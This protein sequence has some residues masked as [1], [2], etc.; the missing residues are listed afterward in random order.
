MS[1]CPVTTYQPRLTTDTI[2]GSLQGMEVSSADPLARFLWQPQPVAQA[3]VAGLTEKFLTLCPAARA[4]AA[5]MR[6]ETAT[7]FID[8]IDHLVVPNGPGLSDQLSAAGFRPVSRHGADGVFANPDGIFPDILVGGE[9][10]RAG[11]AVDSVSDAAAALGIAGEIAGAPASPH[12]RA[13]LI[14]AEHAELWAIERHG[15]DGYRLPAWTAEQS[16]WFLHHLD[17]FRIR[18]RRFSSETEGFAFTNALIDHAIADLG[19]DIACDVFFMAE[20]DYWQRRNRAARVQKGRQDQLGLGWA[21]HDHHTYRS[22]RLWFAPLIATL[23]RLGFMCR[24]R[25]YAGREAGWG[26]QVLEH[27][28][29][30]IVIFADVDMS[31]EEVMGD[32]SHHPMTESDHLG[33][34]GLWCGLHGEAFFQA[35]MHHLE[36]TFDYPRLRDQ[37]AE[38]GI[39]S[40][41]PF[42]DY[43]HLHQA[44]TEGEQW[45][46]DAK[47]VEHLLR[48]GLIDPKQA[49]AF[50]DQGAIGSHLENLERND[51]FKGFNQKGVSEIIAGTD[52]R[53]QLGA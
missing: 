41:K 1:S 7:R 9:T 17:A 31:A 36:C 45:K 28:V 50:K 21:N 10:V 49:T 51:G 33:T 14:A 37:L 23:E 47:R 40:M 42:T 35:G 32:F 5:R 8:W 13:C 15:Y 3:F 29:T 4:L 46:V 6:D 30:G 22:S 2:N 27:P 52:P 34:V 16:R 44:F 24:E 20:R 53:L 48:A 38:H 25:F 12:R 26:A 43:P 18:R 19:R 39:S 11:I